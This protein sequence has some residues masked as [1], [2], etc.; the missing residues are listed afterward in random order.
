MFPSND[1]EIIAG[2]GTKSRENFMEREFPKKW[3]ANTQI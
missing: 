1:G 2:S 3:A